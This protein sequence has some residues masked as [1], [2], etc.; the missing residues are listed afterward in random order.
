M[1]SKCEEDEA[2]KPCQHS[3]DGANAHSSTLAIPHWVAPAQ[4]PTLLHPQVPDCLSNSEGVFI[5]SQ[6]A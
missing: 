1:G 3:V 4:S 6:V 2:K 5:L